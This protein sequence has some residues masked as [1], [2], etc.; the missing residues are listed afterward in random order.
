MIATRLLRP[1]RGVLPDP[2]AQSPDQALGRRFRRGV[3]R[4]AQA[5]LQRCPGAA[6][7][8]GP[9]A[10]VPTVGTTKPNVKKYPVSSRRLSV[11]DLLRYAIR[12]RSHVSKPSREPAVHGS[13]QFARLLVAPEPRRPL[14]TRYCGLATP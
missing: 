6:T 1:L 2:N 13:E 11:I 10:I 12:G 4:F 7:P 5:H 14:L 3:S 9:I 8:D